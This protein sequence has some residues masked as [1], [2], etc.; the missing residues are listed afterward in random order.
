MTLIPS[1]NNKPDTRMIE[2]DQ[3]VVRLGLEKA[4]EQ[5]KLEQIRSEVAEIGLR[6]ADILDEIKKSELKLMTI[7]REISD[8][9][10][11]ETE[12]I[13]S[14]S[15]DSQKAD[16]LLKDKKENLLQLEIYTLSLR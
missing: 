14:F 8:A 2:Y 15:L 10:E 5:A 13:K 9:V 3:A 1:K 12:Y 7:R 11:R 6:S 16:G 4:R